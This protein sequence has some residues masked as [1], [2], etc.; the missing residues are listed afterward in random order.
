MAKP[1]ASIAVA[2]LAK[3]FVQ[4][5]AVDVR[6]LR[7]HEERDQAVRDLAGQPDARRRDRAGIDRQRVAGM[8]DA[9]QRL[10]EPCR[11][12]AAVGERVV[13]AFVDHRL[14]AR[15]DL[16]DDRDVFAQPLVG[17]AVRD[18]VPAFDDLRPRRADAEDE[19]A[20]GERLQGHR[21]HR[22]AGGRARGHLH[23]RGA[24][25]D[26][27]RPGQDPGGRCYRIGTVRLRGPDRAIAERLR[28]TDQVCVDGNAPARIAEHE[29]ELQHWS[30][31]PCARLG[32]AAVSMGR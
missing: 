11:V 15:D 6:A 18:S 25:R 21:G 24:D 30:S 10:A 28:L 22:G 20:A 14:L 26:P 9:L 16:A 32:D 19:S 17:L 5:I 31:P 27:L 7:H 8:D 1:S 29:P 2:A 4:R 12:R 3:A 13:H 23:E